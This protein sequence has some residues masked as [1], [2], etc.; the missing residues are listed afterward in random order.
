MN[1]RQ[2]FYHSYV[3]SKLLTCINPRLPFSRDS[4]S[5]S[6]NSSILGY[7]TRD[8]HI[9]QRALGMLASSLLV[10][11]CE[12]ISS[13]LGVGQQTSARLAFPSHRTRKGAICKLW[14]LYTYIA[15]SQ[16]YSQPLIAWRR[17]ELSSQFLPSRQVVLPLRIHNVMSYC[18]LQYVGTDSLVRPLPCSF[19]PSNQRKMNK[20]QSDSWI[21]LFMWCRVLSRASCIKPS[22][23]TFGSKLASTQ[24]A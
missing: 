1:Y 9:W 22:H 24:L 19:L 13:L 11:K 23:G 7:C 3:L 8:R 21:V 14:M 20:F 10:G 12:N 6:T 2:L 16:M 17:A 4:E 18:P 5:I 15:W